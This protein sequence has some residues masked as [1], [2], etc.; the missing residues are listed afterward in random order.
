MGGPMAVARATVP[1]LLV[2][3][4]L[5]AGCG[6]GD[7]TPSAANQDLD[8]PEV[9]RM[10]AAPAGAAAG[11]LSAPSSIASV[12]FLREAFNSAQSLW[13]QKFDAVD[14]DYEPARLTFFE[15]AVDTACG[16]QTAQT[17]PFYCPAGHGVYLNTHWFDT[18]ARTFGLRSP[19][20]PGYVV[21]HEVAH[22]VQQLLGL[23][24]R[25]AAAD[26]ADRAG[27]NNRSVR[28]ELQA[29][30]YAGIWLHY[31]ARAGQ[32]SQA[33]VDDILRA[34]AIVGDD[35][36]RNKAGAELAPET[37]TH[38]SSAQRVHWLSVGKDTGRP[39]DCDT[40]G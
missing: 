35:F 6:G 40:F 13:R 14:L 1:A 5:L 23:H 33:D 39:G 38:G 9:A 21:A 11:E 22:H 27:A 29:D 4:C 3:I 32:L 16:H 26:A 34:A 28:V 24:A 19:F 30:C 15:T 17:G 31:V 10:P 7:N 8:S 36:Q 2:L 18:L 25:V 20:A 37:W 12:A